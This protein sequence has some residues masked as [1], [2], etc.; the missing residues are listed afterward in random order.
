LQGKKSDVTHLR[1]FPYHYPI[2]ADC[3]SYQPIWGYLTKRTICTAPPCKALLHEAYGGNIDFKNISKFIDNLLNIKIM[4]PIIKF[5][6]ANKIDM[7]PK[8]QRKNA[9]IL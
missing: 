2:K 7:L 4:F 9:G 8:G 6:L 3:G 1:S 5:I